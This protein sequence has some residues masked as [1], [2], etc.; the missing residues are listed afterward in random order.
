[1]KKIRR[2]LSLALGLV[3]SLAL[4][5]PAMAYGASYEFPGGFYDFYPESGEL[6]YV[7]ISTTDP[8]AHT[9]PAVIDG[10]PVRSVGEV[11]GDPSLTSLTVSEGIVS[12]VLA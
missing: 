2:I 3:L 1:M 4:A 6:L 11:V 7:T 5:V 8:V 9:I 10:V 12:F